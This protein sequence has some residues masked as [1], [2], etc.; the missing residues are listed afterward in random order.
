M[1]D[2]EG[3]PAK[4][5]LLKQW[6]F[7]V[8]VAAILGAVLFVPYICETANCMPCPEGVVCAPCPGPECQGLAGYSIDRL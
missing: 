3:A 6:W 8:I 2:Q 1:A 4:K 7:W 5:N